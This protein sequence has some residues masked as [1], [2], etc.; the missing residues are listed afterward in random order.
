MQK[1]KRKQKFVEPIKKL[2]V[3]STKH[4]WKNKENYCKKIM[5]SEPPRSVSLG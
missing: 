5:P 2:Y 3:T 1:S 4:I